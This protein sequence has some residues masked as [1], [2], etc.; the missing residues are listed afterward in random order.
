LDLAHILIDGNRDPKSTLTKDYDLIIKG[1]DQ[2]FAIALASLFSKEY[3]DNFMRELGENDPR[4][5]L[6]EFAKNKGYGT[7][8]H[9]Q[10]IR[11]YGLSDQH[12]IE[13]STKLITN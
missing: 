7:D 10:L 8:L 11:K 2:S 9:T 4:Y 3:R 5:A 6:Y 12:R 1:D 13:A